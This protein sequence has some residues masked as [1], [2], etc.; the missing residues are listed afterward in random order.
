MIIDDFKKNLLDL[1]EQ[2]ETFLKQTYDRSLS[3][4]DGFFDR[5]ERATRLGFGEGASIYNSALVFGDVK[6]GIKT[7]IG[8][9]VMLDGSGGGIKIGSYCSISSAVHIYTHDSVMWALSGGKQSFTQANVV[10]G[11]NTYIG[12]QSVIKA[13]VK[14]GIH[15]LIGA[16]TFVNQDVD[17]YSILVG[18]PARVIGR[19]VITNG[20][21]SLERSEERR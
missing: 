12:A 4:Q 1:Y 17:D 10:I 21:V 20:E 11:D 3:F 14:I 18:S 16:N 5:F 19:V 6:V 15:C 13:G 9:Y 7:W 2:Q 8:P